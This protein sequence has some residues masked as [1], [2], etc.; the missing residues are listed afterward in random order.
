MTMVST[1]TVPWMKLGQLVDEPMTAKEAAELGGLN[2]EVQKRPIFF[3]A[4]DGD[5]EMTA[6]PDRVAIVRQDTNQWLGI[7]A[8]NYQMLQY[9]E[10]FDF[11]DTVNPKY[12]AA[13]CLKDGK[14]GFMV[15]QTDMTMHVLGDDDPH[16]LYMILRTSHD[17]SRAVEVSL[18]ALR[19]R[20]MNQ[21]ALQ[22]FVSG[23]ENRWSVKHT[24]TMHGKLVEAHTAVTKMDAYARTFEQNAEKLAELPV[25]DGVAQHILETVLP[26]RPRRGEQIERIITSWHTSETVGFDHQ[27]WGL[28]NAVSEYFDWGRAGGSPES[29]FVSAMQ[30]QTYKTI[31]STAKQ[32]LTLV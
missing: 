11:M 25:T 17:G 9:G 16:E 13:G 2:F 20:C 32:L 12:V 31:N 15:V 10:A 7:M 29:R 23:V 26:E 28:L 4:N 1:R 8:P 19:N 30:G 21:L 5:S 22:S 6:I 3:Q 14:Q 27:G 18:Q 24:S